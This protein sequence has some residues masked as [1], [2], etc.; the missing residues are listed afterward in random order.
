MSDRQTTHW[1]GCEE[2]HHDCALA[3]LEEARER[4][5]KAEAE[6]AA[7]K[8]DA[9]RLRAALGLVWTIYVREHVH[10]G[11]ERLSGFEQQC[12]PCIC[13]LALGEA[14]DESPTAD[15]FIEARQRI[16]DGDV[17]RARQS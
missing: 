13:A 14:M 17:D 10:L 8:E 9:E 12:I 11:L 15:E 6:L 3:R 7:V 1:E 16:K 2:A 5:L 4:A